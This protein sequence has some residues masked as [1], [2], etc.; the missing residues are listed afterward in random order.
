VSCSAACVP[1]TCGEGAI[2]C[3]MPKRTNVSTSMICNI[4]AIYIYTHTYIYL[5]I[6]IHTYI[7][8]YIYILYAIYI[9]HIY[10]YAIYI[11]HDPW[12][13]KSSELI[14]QPLDRWKSGTGKVGPS[15]PSHR[16]RQLRAAHRQDTRP[17]PS[18]SPPAFPVP[19]LRFNGEIPR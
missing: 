12:F 1:Y 7:H 18:I 9:C 6:Y 3:H 11:C 15:L 16:R 14:H 17:Q 4:Y 2:R 5:H 13:I 19:W 8:T 10:I